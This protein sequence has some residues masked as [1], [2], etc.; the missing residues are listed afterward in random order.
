MSD[1][2]TLAF[3]DGKSNISLVVQIN[4]LES[5]IAIH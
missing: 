3:E 4:Y 5:H 1:K 2:N